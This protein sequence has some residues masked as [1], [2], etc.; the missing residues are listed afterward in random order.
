MLELQATQQVHAEIK[1]NESLWPTWIEC[2]KWH[3]MSLTCWE[4]TE[5]RYSDSD[6]TVSNCWAGS[7]ASQSRAAKCLPYGHFKLRISSGPAWATG[8]WFG[9]TRVSWQ[10]LAEMTSQDF[11]LP[12]FTSKVSLWLSWCPWCRD[13]IIMHI[14]LAECRR[15]DL[16]SLRPSCS[17][18]RSWTCSRGRSYQDMPQERLSNKSNNNLTLNNMLCMCLAKWTVISHHSDFPSS[19]I[20]D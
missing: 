11:F 2:M 19:F 8:S 3:S 18:W 1:W 13:E 20:S 16:I 17:P 6:T 12:E 10:S 15:L 7:T 5:Y 4:E 9:G 14:A